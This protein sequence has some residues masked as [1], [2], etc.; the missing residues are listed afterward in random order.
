MRIGDDMDES[1]RAYGIIKLEYRD[2]LSFTT[3][4]IYN[5]PTGNSVCSDGIY[6]LN[7]VKL[8]SDNSLP[9]GIYLK[10]MNG[11]TI[12]ILK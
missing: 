10:R 11:K 6:N 4:G 12:K 2:Y 3:T 9:N 7:G 8:P 1:V 5:V